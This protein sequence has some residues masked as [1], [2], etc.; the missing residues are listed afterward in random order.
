MDIAERRVP[1]DGRAHVTIGRRSSSGQRI[2]LR[3]S[4]LPT[5]YGERLSCAARSSKSDHLA[6][7]EALGMPDDVRLPRVC[8]TLQR[9]RAGHRADGLGQDHHALR[10]PAMAR[11]GGHGSTARDL[12]IMTIEDPIEYELGSSQPRSVRPR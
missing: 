10:D 2:D 5:A 3:V 9:H 7:F 8:F 1:Q 4:T 12:N 11:R 6:S